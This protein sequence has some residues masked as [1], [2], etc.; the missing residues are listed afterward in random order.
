MRILYTCLLFLTTVQIHAQKKATPPQSTPVARPKLVVGLVIDQMRWDYLYRYY[1]RYS[2]NGFKRLLSKGFSAEN[3]MIPYTP[4]VTACGHTCLYTGSVPAIHGITGNNFYDYDSARVMYCAEDRAM[5]PLGTGKNGEPGMMSPKNMKT[6]TICDELRLATNFK[7]KVV[8][9]AIKDRGAILPAGHAANSAFWYDNLSGNWVSS[10]YYM[11]ALPAWVNKFNERKVVDSFYKLG[12][13]TLYD[14]TTYLQSDNDNNHKYEGTPFGNKINSFPYV[15]DTMVGKNYK[16]IAYTPAGNRMTFMMAKEAMLNESLGKDNI[17]DF[18][19]IS[20]SSP[21]YI[22]HVFGPNSIEQEDDFLRLDLQID[23]FL[24]FLDAQVGAG[25]YTLFLSA[26]HGVAHNPVYLNEH[27]MPGNMR[28]LSSK[29]DWNAKLKEAFGVDGLV[30]SDEEYQVYLDHTKIAK[31]KLDANKILEFL[32]N[33]IQKMDGVARVIRWDAL[34][35]TPMPDVQRKYLNNSYYPK[36]CGDLMI[37]LQPGW[38]DQKD[39]KGTTHGVWNPYDAH[40]PL[41]FYGWGIQPGKTNRE[42]YMTDAAA[43]LA[44]LLKIQMPNG[45]VGHVVTEALK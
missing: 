41:L 42:T 3:T 22:G 5:T 45:C 14:S 40:I 38:I 8:G 1:N 26:D 24:Q 16:A 7:G 17:T 34:Q 36:R 33:D 9:V 19:A 12:W 6:N 20:L 21:D 4:T 43:T 15:L 13:S 11:N 35:Q 28:Y 31:E 2:A 10:S 18:L 39:E 32:T 30:V 37:V 29:K 44:A 25:N 27:K 23:Q